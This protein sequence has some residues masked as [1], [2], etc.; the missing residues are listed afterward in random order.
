MIEIRNL[1]KNY[2]KKVVYKKLDLTFPEKEI[3]CIIGPSGCG[4]TTLLR[5]LAGLETADQ[6]EILG[7]ANKRKAFVF[8]EDRLMP[9]LSVKENIKYVLASSYSKEQMNQK[10]DTILALLKLEEEANSPVQKLSGGMKRRVAIGRALVFES[11]LLLL[12]EPFKGLDEELK[13]H[14]LNQMLAYLKAEPRTVICVTHDQEVAR[15][16]GNVIDIGKCMHQSS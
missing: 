12:D 6:G 13:W 2:G 3:S 11:D 8:Q 15:Y 1:C 4:K 14:V 9:W 10:I 7:V 5:I 16:L